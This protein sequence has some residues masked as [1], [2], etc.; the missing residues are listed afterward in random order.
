M[1]R[2]LECVY[3]AWW[4]GEL[5]GQVGIFP[6]NHV[7]EVKEEEVVAG[8]DEMDEGAMEGEVFGE[9]GMV[10]RLLGMM[11]GMQGRGAGVADNEE[12][13][14]LYQRSMALR[15]KVVK[16][17]ERYERKQGKS[18]LGLLAWARAPAD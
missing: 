2:V 8:G 18:I 9:A 14:E 10:D 4:K 12:L 6:A 7:E 3:E 5:R 17:I 1:I 16:L 15:P 13:V 11:R